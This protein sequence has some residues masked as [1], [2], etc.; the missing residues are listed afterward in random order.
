MARLTIR[1][2]EKY[3]GKVHA[4]RG[5]DLAL[6]VQE[7]RPAEDRGEG[8]PE[9]VGHHVHELALHPVERLQVTPYSRRQR[10]V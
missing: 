2:L 5:V 9:V 7:L 1:G 3:Y 8:G 10:A 4:L 6:G